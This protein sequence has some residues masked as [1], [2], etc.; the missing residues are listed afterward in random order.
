M[1]VASEKFQAK[2]LDW[3]VGVEDLWHFKSLW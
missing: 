1:V 2:R 3:L